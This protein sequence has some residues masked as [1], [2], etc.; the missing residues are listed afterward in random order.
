MASIMRFDTLQ[1]M[2]GN[3]ALTVSSSGNI[4]IPGSTVQVVQSTKTDVFSTT[5]TSYTDVTGLSV[6]ISP[7]FS[8]SKILVIG[9]MVLAKQVFLLAPVLN[10]LIQFKA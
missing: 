5:S 1:S 9:N 8:T 6:S 3:N 4:N 10:Y 7:K 2:T